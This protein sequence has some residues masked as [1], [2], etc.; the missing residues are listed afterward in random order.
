MPGL[1]RRLVAACALLA[2][3][4]PG[5]AQWLGP[6]GEATISVSG[7]AEL[8]SDPDMILWDIVI[9][10]NDVDPSAAK[11]QNDER[12]E[13]L[14][15]IADDLDLPAEDIVAG[16]LSI[17]RTYHRTERGQRGAFKDY[18][19]RRWATLVLRDFDD[20][21]EMLEMLAGAGFEFSIEYSS[22]EIHTMKREARLEA[23]RVA[24][25]KAQE[26]AEVLGQALGRPLVIDERGSRVAG[27]DLN[28]ALSNTNTGGGGRFG[29]ERE[30]VGLR[31]GA[32]SVTAS[33]SIV[34]ELVQPE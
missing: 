15:E 3:V 19:V 12:Y 23:V 21:D 30:A 2:F 14:L 33:V 26:M 20:F 32:I 22:T 1:L 25:E 6:D 34:F 18:E 28:D 11:T 5:H 29:D 7:T 4:V 17:R 27:F 13:A 31:Q 24:R 10:D 9:V 16:T 8:E